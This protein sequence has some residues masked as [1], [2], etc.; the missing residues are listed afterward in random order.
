M[1]GCLQEQGG[2]A[3]NYQEPNRQKCLLLRPAGDKG[4][5]DGPLRMF[6]NV[7]KNR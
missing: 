6:L 2:N 4:E 5:N 3:T 7:V 1:L